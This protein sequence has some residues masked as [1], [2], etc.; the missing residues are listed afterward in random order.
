MKY[1]LLPTRYFAKFLL[2]IVLVGCVAA[3]KDSA[4]MLS[5]QAAETAVIP[6]AQ[7]TLPNVALDSG[8][9]YKILV[10]EVAGQR[11]QFEV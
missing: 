5:S 8:L 2:V 3:H 4:V 1:I 7:S 11:G 10:A 6:P 9:M